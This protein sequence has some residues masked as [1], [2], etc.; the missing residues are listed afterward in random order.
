MARTK[1]GPSEYGIDLSKDDSEFPPGE[2]SEWRRREDGT[3][4]MI[5]GDLPEEIARRM[6][7]DYT[8]EGETVWTAPAP[9]SHT[10]ALSAE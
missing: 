4:E 9:E 3:P 6:V 1:I 10:H 2:W 5:K 8:A 7:A